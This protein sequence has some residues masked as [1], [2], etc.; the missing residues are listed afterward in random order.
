MSGIYHIWAKT[1]STGKAYMLAGG[2][3]WWEN[4]PRPIS[5]PFGKFWVRSFGNIFSNDDFTNA[6]LGDFGEMRTGHFNYHASFG[7]SFEKESDA[8]LFKMLLGEYIIET[9]PF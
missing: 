8:V 7:F 6:R 2:D 4:G 9:Y 1:S 3:D 5:Y